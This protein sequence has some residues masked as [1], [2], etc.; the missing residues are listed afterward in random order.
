MMLS[1]TLMGLSARSTTRSYLLGSVS[2]GT[3]AHTGWSFVP[4]ALR[5]SMPVVCSADSLR[6]VDSLSQRSQEGSNC[7]KASFLA[8]SSSKALSLAEPSSPIRSGQVYYSAE[9]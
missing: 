6:K 3:L 8:F 2:M 5:Q 1:Y 4:S 7:L 9:V